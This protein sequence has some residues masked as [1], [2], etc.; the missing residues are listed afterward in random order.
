VLVVSKP[1][2]HTFSPLAVHSL[3]TERLRP[4]GKSAETP[5]GISPSSFT[6]DLFRSH[7]EMQ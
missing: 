4:R 1:C 2:A 3:H 7:S 5:T 6:A